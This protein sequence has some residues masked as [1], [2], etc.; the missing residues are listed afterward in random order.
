MESDK[1]RRRRLRH[2]RLCPE[3]ATRVAARKVSSS[4]IPRPSV[5]VF[6]NDLGMK[7]VLSCLSHLLLVAITSSKLL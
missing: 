5:P 7:L 6:Q 2:L 1:K 3:S 4:L